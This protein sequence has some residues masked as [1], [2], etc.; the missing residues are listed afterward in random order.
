[1]CHGELCLYFFILMDTSSLGLCTLSKFRLSWHVYQ[2]LIFQRAAINSI[3]DHFRIIY[4]YKDSYLENRWHRPVVNMHCHLARDC[5]RRLHV[6]KLGIPCLCQDVVSPVH[7]TGETLRVRLQHWLVFYTRCLY[8]LCI[9]IIENSPLKVRPIPIL[10]VNYC[11]ITCTNLK[12][13]K[14]TLNQLQH[15]VIRA[16]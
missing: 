1:M 8:A 15:V 6:F 2:V 4:Y 13:F 9:N 11:T 7:S 5:L 12:H 16:H 14:Q 10:P 3:F